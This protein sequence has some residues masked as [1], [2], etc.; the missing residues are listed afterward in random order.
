M[1]NKKFDKRGVDG[2]RMTDCA[3]AAHKTDCAAAA[4][5]D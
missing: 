3:A 4:H 5:N 1:P 2:R